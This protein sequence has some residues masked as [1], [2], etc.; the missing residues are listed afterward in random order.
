MM[1]SIETNE[2][3]ISTDGEY[4]FDV[5]DSKEEAIENLRDSY[6]DGYIGKCVEI[7]FAE[8][9]IIPY[10][11]IGHILSETLSDEVGEASEDWEFTTEQEEE[12]SQIVA[13]A[14]ID[15]INKNHL[16]P[17]CYKVIDIEFIEVGEQE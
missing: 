2:W 1:K 13:K 12:I 11:E 9:D 15:Y 7:E 17:R 5:Y 8:E 4:F 3:C 14:V 16:Q 10:I 6:N